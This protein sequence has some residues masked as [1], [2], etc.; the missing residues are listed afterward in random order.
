MYLFA[1]EYLRN[2]QRNDHQKDFYNLPFKDT[3]LPFNRY[4]YAYN[5]AG[6]ETAF[7]LKAF[8]HTSAGNINAAMTEWVRRQVEKTFNFD[9]NLMELNTED[10]VTLAARIYE[11]TRLPNLEFDFQQNK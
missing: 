10:K 9:T 3:N 5:P 4:G 8:G 6:F 11:A 7:A 1:D 2:L